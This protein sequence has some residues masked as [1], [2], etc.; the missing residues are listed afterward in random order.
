MKL[1]NKTDLKL[2][3]RIEVLYNLFHGLKISSI[4]DEL[5]DSEVVELQK[6][7]WEKTVE[8]GIASRGKNFSRKEITRKMTPTAVFQ[9]QH[10]CSESQYHCKGVHCISTNPECGR[11]KIKEHIDIMS[12]S[13]WDYI[14][15]D[16]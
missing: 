10:N 1:N 16:V 13:I 12:E 9:K 15:K 3:T 4:I 5:G 6:F 7:V 8:F 2:S 11:E 14:S